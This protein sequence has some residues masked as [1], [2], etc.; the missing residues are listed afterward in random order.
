[1]RRLQ[2]GY[3]SPVTH[4]GQANTHRPAR[5]V[6]PPAR[7]RTVAKLPLEF[8]LLAGRLPT[9]M[10]I[11]LCRRCQSP[12]RSEFSVGSLTKH[13][14]G[15]K[16][17]SLTTSRFG[18][19]AQYSRIR[20]RKPKGFAMNAAFAQLGCGRDADGLLQS[21]RTAAFLSSCLYFFSMLAEAAY[22]LYR[23]FCHRSVIRLLT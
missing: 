7:R 19:L 23:R 16:S 2:T 9:R 3:G 14:Y 12:A 13:S 17:K 6:V 21:N 10:R 5:P 8:L 11:S 20:W 22:A 4:S 15:Y 1:M 18:S